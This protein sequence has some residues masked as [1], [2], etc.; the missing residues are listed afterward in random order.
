[1][2]SEDTNYVVYVH[3][4]A[5]GSVRYVGSG[6]IKRA[7]ETHAKSSRGIKYQKFVEQRGKL[8][9]EIIQTGLSKIESLQREITLFDQYMITDLLLNKNRPYIGRNTVDS[10]V[11]HDLFYY[12]ETSPSALR[13]K[14][15]TSNG[16]AGCGK[17]AGILSSTGYYIVKINSISY[18]V[19]RIIL[20]MHGINLSGVVVDHINGNRKDNRLDNL[21]VCTFAENSRNRSKILTTNKTL[22]NGISIHKNSSVVA[23]LI[24][25]S[26][27]L[28]SGRHK[29]ITKSFAIKKYGL[30]LAIELAVKARK[31]MEDK[32]LNTLGIK[33]TERHGK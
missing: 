3:K 25:P 17:V 24:N 6:R 29:E 31:E 14:I 9:Y 5:E 16:K 26:V 22:P 10:H 4:D 21:R 8:F 19:S 15:K 23:R 28:E 18:T 1:M 20:M 7:K 32:L 12:D 2:T 33:Y 13:W 11:L 27:I 30:D